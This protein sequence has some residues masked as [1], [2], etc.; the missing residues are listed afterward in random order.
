ML[1]LFSTINPQRTARSPHKCHGFSGQVKFKWQSKIEYEIRSLMILLN[2]NLVHK[3]IPRNFHL[4]DN[5]QIKNAFQKKY[6]LR[7]L[8]A[9]YLPPSSSYPTSY[10]EPE[11]LYKVQSMKYKEKVQST[12]QPVD[13]HPMQSQRISTRYE[14]YNVQQKYKVYSYPTVYAEPE[15]L[16]MKYKV[17]RKKKKV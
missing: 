1:S 17:K 12:Q 15:Y 6:Y 5:K 11:D 8:S 16:F 9:A 13:Q 4:G 2:S 14:V 7:D 3:Y 10:A